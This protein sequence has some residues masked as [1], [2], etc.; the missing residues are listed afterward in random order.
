MLLP[1]EDPAVDSITP[2]WMGADWHERE[3]AEM[4]GMTFRGHPN[5]KHL[6]LD[7][8]MEIHPLLKAHPLAPIEL[9][10]GDHTS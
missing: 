10:Q 9:K 8:D 4:F 2:I 1:P 6:L 5:P 3:N 7:D